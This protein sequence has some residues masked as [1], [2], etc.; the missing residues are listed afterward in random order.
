[1]T[2]ELYAEMN[3]V[4]SENLDLSIIS[5]LTGIKDAEI[6]PLSDKLNPLT[7]KPIE[8][9]WTI[10]TSRHNTYDLVNVLSEMVQIVTPHISVIMDLCN[11]YSG[12]VNF[13]IIASFV[14]NQ[15]PA[16]YFER[17][18]L[19]VASMMNATIQIDMYPE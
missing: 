7:G 19:N 16:L 5:D 17:D 1:M 4:F 18:F 14:S 9:S 8:G 11:K 13:C 3:L 15:V 2:P 12:D 6:H 10:Q